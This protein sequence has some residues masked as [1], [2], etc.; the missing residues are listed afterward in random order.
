MSDSLNNLTTKELR[1]LALDRG[2]LAARFMSRGSLLRDLR[3]QRLTPF[4]HLYLLPIVLA[5]Q[6]VVVVGLVVT[7]LVQFLLL[8]F[9]FARWLLARPSKPQ[10][11]ASKAVSQVPKRATAT[12]P[13]VPESSVS[14]ILVQVRE[15]LI[16]E[17]T[18]VQVLRARDDDT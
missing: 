12:P 3:R 18:I 5:W 11:T 6:L 16:R 17:V 9:K 13:A 4:Q 14:L 2:V 15:V 8:P 10:P 7:L 1:N